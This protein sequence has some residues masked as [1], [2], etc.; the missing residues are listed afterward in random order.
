MDKNL[1]E[2]K[3]K[4]PESGFIT[5]MDAMEIGKAIAMIGG[6]RLKVKDKIDQA[7][8]YSCDLKIGDKVKEHEP[9]GT[10]YCRNEV[11]AAKILARLQMAYKIGL[12]K[13]V[14]K[15]ELVKEIIS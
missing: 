10:L 2:V 5:G 13:N 4:S 3:I 8:G 12:E 15:F 14:R 7:V 11:Q 9:L 1:L 6:G